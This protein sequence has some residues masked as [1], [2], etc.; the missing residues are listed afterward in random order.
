M[1]VLE[2]KHS[3][4]LSIQVPKSE[5]INYSGDIKE[6]NIFLTV[7]GDLGINHFS[8]EG[9]LLPIEIDTNGWPE[10]WNLVSFRL[11]SFK[12]WYRMT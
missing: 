12:I 3:I 10:Q 2:S 4:E 8:I 11:F 6:E 5:Y 7:A 1:P 9:G